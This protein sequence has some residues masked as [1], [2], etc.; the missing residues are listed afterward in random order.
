MKKQMLLKDEDIKIQMTYK[1][2]KE[3]QRVVKLWADIQGNEEACAKLNKIEK[4]EDA[5][6]ILKSYVSMTFEQFKTIE[7]SVTE[8]LVESYQ[9]LAAEAERELG[10]DE[11]DCVTGGSWFSNAWNWVKQNPIKTALIVASV[12][13]IATG[14]GIAIAGPAAIA[15]SA[16]ASLGAVA[17]AVDSWQTTVLTLGLAGSALAGVA[18]FAMAVEDK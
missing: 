15:S 3:M 14:I 4:P 12:A 5:Y 8:Q 1:S 17:G 2:E 13:L 16:T 9:S 10:E 11:L 18:S 6:D 7:K